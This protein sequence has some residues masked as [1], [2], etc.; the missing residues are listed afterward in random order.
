MNTAFLKV[1][2]DLLKQKYDV[3][4]SGSTCVAVL[5]DR[6]TIFCANAGDSR[7]VLYSVNRN[8]GSQG[9][10]T[11]GITPLSEDHKPCLPVERKR[12]ISVGGRVDTIKGNMGQNLGPMRVWLME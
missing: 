4:L 7:A 11:C 2:E 12:V 8:Q 6:N 1:H 5:F 10:S 3:Q 9:K